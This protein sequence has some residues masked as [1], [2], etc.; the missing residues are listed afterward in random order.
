MN[1]KD[2][3]AGIKDGFPICVGYFSVSIAFGLFCVQEGMPAWL[4]VF[5]S[6]TNLTSAGQFAGATLLL[7]QVN[8]IELIV[9]LFV[10]NMRYFFMSFSISQKL[11]DNFPMWKRFIAGFGITDEVFAVSMQ[12]KESLTAPYML[13]VIIPPIVGWTLGTLTG[14]VANSLLPGV[15]TDAMGIALYA[16][17]IAI[18][19]PPAKEEKN[20]L[21]AVVMAIAASYLFTYLPILRNLSSGWVVIIITISVS[22][23]A[24]ILFPV[25]EKEEKINES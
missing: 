1:R 2:F 5:I 25:E 15:V 10:I 14:A 12:R 16:M 7:E 20:V 21:V 19:V 24:A 8:Y 4:A 9:T 22:L 11:A 13:G 3:I 6:L 18:I 17:F 23:I